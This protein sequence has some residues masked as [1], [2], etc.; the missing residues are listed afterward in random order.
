MEAVTGVDF[1]ER[2]DIADLGE[3]LIPA[4]MR[5]DLPGGRPSIG[6]RLL[7]GLQNGLA[8]VGWPGLAAFHALKSPWKDKRLALG[9][10]DAAGNRASPL[11]S[12]VSASGRG[13][14]NRCNG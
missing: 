3:E 6:P 10:L 13:I 14:S 5:E 9:S 4:L 11:A 7:M 8:L 12:R 1:A 2:E